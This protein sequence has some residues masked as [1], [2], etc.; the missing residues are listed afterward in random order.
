MGKLLA[1]SLVCTLQRGCYFSPRSW[2]SPGVPA[3]IR[4][5]TSSTGAV[6]AAAASGTALFVEAGLLRTFGVLAFGGRRCRGRGRRLNPGPVFPRAQE[7]DNA[8]FDA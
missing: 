8:S 7:A 2:V 6:F 3:T 1:L 5:Q 4:E